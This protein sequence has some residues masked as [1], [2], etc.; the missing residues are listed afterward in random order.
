[1]D[2]Y[3]HAAGIVRSDDRDRYLSDLLAPD[4]ARGHLLVLHAFNAEIARVRDNTNEP[5]LG[6]MRL[7]FWRDALRGDGAGHPIARALVE[8]IA[9][10]GLPLTAFEN[11]IEARRFDLYNDP[12]PSLND[13]EGYA[14]ETSSSLIQLAA[15]ILA[16]GQDRGTAE[17][18]GHG[19]VAY[20]LT[21][22]IRSL[23]IHAARRQCYLPADLLAAHDVD[24]ETVFAGKSTPALL[25][26][27]GELRSIATKHIDT[28]RS[29]SG[30]LDS[31]LFPALLPVALVSAQL[32]VMDRRGYDPFG[33]KEGVS[34]LRRQWILWRAARRRAI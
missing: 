7:Q 9:T 17:I 3:A 4:A 6:E 1:M 26:A 25:S 33:L 8:T 23:P 11:L 13:L 5:G 2:I 14:G 27:L 20:A 18:A 16:G 30:E 34:P 10:F 22:M 32:G 15:I 29:L 31:V 12:M 24:L 28:V 19:G 21:G